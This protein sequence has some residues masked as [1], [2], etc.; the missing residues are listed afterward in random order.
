MF[1]LTEEQY[2]ASRLTFGMVCV[3]ADAGTGKTKMVIDKFQYMIE[4]ENIRPE[5]VLAISFTKKS[6]KEIKERLVEKIGKVG[7]KL[8]VNTFHSVFLRIL[9]S[10]YS[11]I[12][13]IEDFPETVFGYKQDQLIVKAFER[14]P[15]NKYTNTDPNIAMKTI[16]RAKTEGLSPKL[17]SK[18][19]SATGQDDNYWIAEVYSYYEELKKKENVIDYGDMLLMTFELLMKQPK[20]LETWRK[21]WDY[22]IIDEFQDT[23]S[24]QFKIIKLLVGDDGNLFVVGD[25]KQAI[26]GFQGANPKFITN[27]KEYFPT[28]T[29]LKLTKTFRCSGRIVKG[30]NKLAHIMG[31][32]PAVTDRKGG[33]VHYL[34]TFEDGEKEAKEV[35]GQIEKLIFEKHVNPKDIAILYRTNLQSSYFES[36]LSQKDIPYVVNNGKSF[37]KKAEVLDII[38]YL[39]ILDDPKGSECAYTWIMNKPNRWISSEMVKLWRSHGINK[40]TGESNYLDAFTKWYPK[41]NQMQSMKHLNGEIRLLLPEKERCSNVGDLIGKIISITGYN[42]Y[43]RS[44]MKNIDDKDDAVTPMDIVNEFQLLS[45]NFKTTDE[46]LKFISNIEKKKKKNKNAVQLMAVHSSKGLEFKVVF[47]VGLSDGLFPHVNGVLEEERCLAYVAFSR[48]KDV[49]IC[50]SYMRKGKKKLLTESIFLKEIGL[51]DKGEEDYE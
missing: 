9:K 11:H 44:K 45:E 1:D 23:N 46:L 8:D 20:L 48:P 17:F 39:R 34:G 41:A 28:A 38:N 7:R 51:L 50:S 47:V 4:N 12:L 16:S 5:K 26:F 49:L 3:G 2:E 24:V 10:G 18:Y 13:G 19:L 14:L 21:A 32:V 43:L 6:V 15:S 42:N 29:M 36:N 40:L 35:V 31:D 30:N 25:K 27:F 37:F 22:I 33:V